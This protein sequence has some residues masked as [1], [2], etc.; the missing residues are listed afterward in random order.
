MK[1][2][3]GIKLVLLLCLDLGKAASIAFGKQGGGLRFKVL[4]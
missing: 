3:L 1:A 4:A 2:A